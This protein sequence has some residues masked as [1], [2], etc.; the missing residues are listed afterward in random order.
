MRLP[1]QRTL[2]TRALLADVVLSDGQ[3]ERLGV[4]PSL[5]PGRQ[6]SVRPG[7]RVRHQ[8]RLVTFRALDE[9]VLFRNDVYGLAHHAGTAEIRQLIGG[10]SSSWRVGGVASLGNEP[11][12]RAWTE[13]GEA[14]LI[15][16]DC[17]YRGR[18]VRDKMKA[19]REEGQV[20]WG[21]PS[22]LRAGRIAQAYPDARVVVTPWWEG[23]KERTVSV[24]GAGG[25]RPDVRMAGSP[26]RTP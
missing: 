4:R 13:D 9:K 21:T 3:L 16:Y 15:E 17:G 6:V 11:D 14:L 20:V 12:A 5:F 10:S 22:P 1:E 2:G 25:G 19:F 7:F 8:E 23:P 26:G 18:V 24:S